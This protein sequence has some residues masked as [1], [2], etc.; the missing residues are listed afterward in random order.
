MLNTPEPTAET[1]SRMLVSANVG[2]ASFNEVSFY[3]KTGK[4][5][6]TYIGTDD[7]R[8]YRVFHDVSDITDGTR[9][10][11]RAVVRDNAGHSSIKRA[12]VP[13]PELTIRLPDEDA[14]VFGR[15]EVRVL[16]DPERASHVV[17]IQRR[18]NGRDWENARTDRS[19]PVYS[20]RDNLSTVP[21]GTTIQYR[22]ILTEPDGTRVDSDV[23]TVTRVAPQPLVSSVTVAGSMQSELGCAN[24]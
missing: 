4:G 15:I 8:P 18:L 9:V 5:G 13:P 12:V 14:E 21:V 24:D 22:A 7:T 1:N 20:Y 2:G 17:R 3:A 19:S 23:R 6:W 16:A 10:S 11:Y